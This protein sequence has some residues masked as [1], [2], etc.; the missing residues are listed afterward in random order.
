MHQYESLATANAKTV[1]HANFF[2]R[3]VVVNLKRKPDRLASFRANFNEHGWPFQEPAVFEAIDGSLVPTPYGWEQGGGAWGCMQSHRQILERAITD[4]VRHLLVFED[5]AYMKAGAVERLY[6]FLDDVPDDWD[7]LMLGGQHLGTTTKVKPGVVK[8]TNCQRTHAYAVRGRFL[9]DLYAHWCSPNSRVH[10]DWIMGPLQSLRN[11]YAPEPFTFGQEAGSSDISGA[12]NPR[13]SWDTP[14]ADLP[15]VLLHAPGHVVKELRRYGLHTGYDRDP[16]TDIDVGLKAVFESSDPVNALHRWIG[17]LQ[18]EVAADEGLVCTVWHPNAT[19][20]A[21]R[22]ACH[23]DVIE[24][25]AETVEDALRQLPSRTTREDWSR[26]HVVVLHAPRRVMAELRGLGWHGG[27]WRDSVTDQDNG[28]RAIFAQ[29]G[30][31]VPQ[32][33]EWVDAV[34]KEVGQ[35][36]GVLCVWHPEASTELVTKATDRRVVEITADTTEEALAKWNEGR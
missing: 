28:L 16:Q 17:D 26:S 25:R 29:D 33:R 10:C 22:N 18:W 3:I 20:E 12:N 30:D 27:H 13:K 2:D 8:V 34:G 24:I 6:K 14:A 19:A 31:K 5:D 1:R 32:L 21:V 9:R 15:V 4:G 36:N 7:Q 35:R 11:V 23:G